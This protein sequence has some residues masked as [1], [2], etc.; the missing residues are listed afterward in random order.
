MKVSFDKETLLSAIGPAAGI[1]QVKNTLTTIEGLLFECPPD[2]KMGAVEEDCANTCRISAFDLEKGLRTTI[3]CKIYEEGKYVINASKILQIVRALPDGEI[4]LEI[5]DKYRAVVSGGQSS[6][7]IAVAD[8]DDFPTMP[9]FIGDR[10]YTFP[11][12]MIRDMINQ[13]IFAVAQNDQR[14]AFNGACMK[15]KDGKMTLVGCDGNRLSCAA[16]KIDGDAPDAEIIIPGKFLQE[17]S[18]LLKDT[19]DETRM[20]IGRKHIIF[21]IGSI[22]FFTRLIE[23]S[24]LDYDRVL[25]KSF[26]TE[27]FVDPD[28][29]RSALERAA[30]ISEDKLGGNSKS[31]V[32]LVFEG[33]M[34]DISCI[35]SSGS[36]Y[37][38]VPAAIG[39]DSLTI[40]FTCR[41]L[42]DALRAC[43]EEV[44]R[45]RI[46]LNTAE[47]GICIEPSYGSSFIEYE[48]GGEQDAKKEDGENK[49]FL[50]FVMPRRMNN[51][52]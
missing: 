12:Y 47:M 28:E 42:L 5:D 4:M 16:C 41:L 51:K 6:F 34:I 39:G 15:I 18:K 25:P 9:M 10:Q 19:E 13:I 24:Y 50:H 36:I 27:A 40:G 38:K 49:D 37:E 44:S 11:Q 21:K 20:I 46:R 45:L 2:E 26:K 30:I 17:L 8:G 14:P 29:L 35:S 3:E 22:Y 43:P 52:N 32:K 23:S 7:E 31:I 33:N 48:N 1:S